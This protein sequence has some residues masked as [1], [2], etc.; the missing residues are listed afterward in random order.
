METVRKKQSGNH[1]K[2]FQ[3]GVVETL[4]RTPESRRSCLVESASASASEYSAMVE[5][6]RMAKF[7][8]RE[9]V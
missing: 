6:T 5:R 3:E 7:G 9:M 8:K 2:H 4:P 1:S